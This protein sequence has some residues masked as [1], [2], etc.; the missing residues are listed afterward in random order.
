VNVIFLP[1]L[2]LATSTWVTAAFLISHWEKDAAAVVITAAIWIALFVL[3]RVV[4]TRHQMKHEWRASED[5]NE[6]NIFVECGPDV[7]L[8]VRTMRCALTHV[9]SGVSEVFEDHPIGGVLGPPGWRS[10]YF[11]YPVA[12]DETG[13]RPRPAAGEYEAV[14]SFLDRAD[15][16]WRPIVRRRFLYVPGSG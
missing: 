9:G 1:L 13:N 8:R 14:W 7:E 11:N 12:D 10:S 4:V 3:F 2:Y 5:T 16:E 15:G 6:S